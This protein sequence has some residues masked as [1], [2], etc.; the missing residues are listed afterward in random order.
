MTECFV[1]CVM[2]V[3]TFNQAYC[4]Y[5]RATLEERLSLV[6]TDRQD[7]VIERVYERYHQRGWS[8]IRTLGE[9]GSRTSDPA[10]SDTTRCVNDCFSWTISLPPLTEH[11]S[12]P[13]NRSTAALTHDPILVSSWELQGEPGAHGWMC[14]YRLS[15][16]IAL[17]YPYLVNHS[18]LT[19]EVCNL[20]RI[21]HAANVD[22]A[23]EDRH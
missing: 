21:A 9:V 7:D 5:P 10:L 20:I 16:P 15:F 3:I 18:I 6:C 17:F 4:L 2:N 14:F 23:A 19:P 11:Q 1:A 12:D 13:I 22:V 8:I